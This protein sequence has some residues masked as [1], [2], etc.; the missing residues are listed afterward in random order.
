MTILLQV[1]TRKIQ[2][3]VGLNLLRQQSS[4][5]TIG[6]GAYLVCFS[7]PLKHGT[8]SVDK[9]FDYFKAKLIE[10]GTPHIDLLYQHLLRREGKIF[11]VIYFTAIISQNDANILLVSCKNLE[12]N[13]GSVLIALGRGGWGEAVDVEHE[14]FAGLLHYAQLAVG[15]E[16]LRKH[17]FLVRHQ[18]REVG[19][20]LGID[21]CHQFYVGTEALFRESPFLALFLGR[22]IRE[23]SVPGTSEVTVA[24]RPLLLAWR[25]MV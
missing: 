20:I 22:V 24:P 12:L 1:Q 16:V 6:Y 21:T 8:L 11:L 7:V 25:E 4:L 23:V 10:L 14:V 2:L 9:G 17:L 19:L 18:P 15:H 3:F 5:G 13:K